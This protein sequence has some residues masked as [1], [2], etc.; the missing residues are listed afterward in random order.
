MLKWL[1][2]CKDDSETANWIS[3]HT[4]DCP[5]CQSAI[6]K[7]GGCN[8]MTCR[9][10]RYEFCWVCMGKEIHLEGCQMAI[11]IL[12]YVPGP[13][14]EHRSQ[15]YACNRFDERSATEARQNQA[16]SRAS[17]ERYLHVSYHALY[18]ESIYIDNVLSSTT[19]AMP[20]M[21]NRQNWIKSYTE[22]RS[23]RWRKYNKTATYPGSRCSS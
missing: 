14:S 10:C 19:T 1:Q 20:T 23:R 5:K 9:K 2:K 7:N 16:K 12:F 17:L 21:T 8:H 18:F 6:E 3:A 11:F 4:K 22:R 15:Y 13:W